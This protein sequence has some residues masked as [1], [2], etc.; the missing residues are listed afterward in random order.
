MSINNCRIKKKYCVVEFS[1]M[2]NCIIFLRSQVRL[3]EWNV[4]TKTDCVRDDCSPDPLD[5]NIEEI[6]PHEDYDPDKGQQNDIALLR[7]ARNVAFNGILQWLIL[8]FKSNIIC[9]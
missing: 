1:I 2:S 9:K 7:L 3:G 4:A 8:N 5:I 6:I